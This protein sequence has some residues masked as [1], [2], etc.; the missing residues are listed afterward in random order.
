MSELFLRTLR[1]DPADAE[2]YPRYRADLARVCQ[3][4]LPLFD[5]APPE[6]LGAAGLGADPEAGAELADLAEPEVGADDAELVAVA[7][8]REVV[9]GLTMRIAPPVG[10][11]RTVVSARPRSSALRRL[12]SSRTR[13]CGERPPVVARTGTAVVGGA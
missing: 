4:V 2:A 3:A 8:S 6:L 12:P 13:R 10:S 1:D 5:Q 11:T 7:P 9:I